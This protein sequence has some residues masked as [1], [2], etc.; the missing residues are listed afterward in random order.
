MPLLNVSLGGT[1]LLSHILCALESP[2]VCFSHTYVCL[3]GKYSVDVIIV[4]GAL[5]FIL[6][7][8]ALADHGKFLLV[9]CKCHRPVNF[10]LGGTMLLSHILCALESPMVCFSH[11]YVCLLG[12]YSVAVI[13]VHGVLYFILLLCAL[14]DHGKFL[15]A[16]CKCHRSA[17]TEYL[18]SLDA[19]NTSKGTYIG[20]LR[21]AF[22][23]QCLKIIT[24]SVFSMR[25]IRSKVLLWQRPRFK[26]FS[27]NQIKLLGNKIYCLWCSSTTSVMAPFTQVYNVFLLDIVYV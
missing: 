20:K 25:C 21:W 23:K 2:M 11:T 13:I 12:K 26:I 24:C 3:L 19:K 4:H 22:T 1:V 15:L 16:A 18:I 5:Y 9:A 14:A 27:V 17:Y 10:S 7:L 6:L 8:C